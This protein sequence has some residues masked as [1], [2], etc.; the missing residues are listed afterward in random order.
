[1]NDLVSSLRF[2]APTFERDPQPERRPFSDLAI[3]V[4]GQR[5]V[6]GAD[7]G[8]NKGALD[9][10]YPHGLL[11]FLLPYLEQEED[12]FVEL[13]CGNDEFPVAFTHVT[14]SQ[15][16]NGERIP[17]F[18]PHARLPDGVIQPVFFRLTRVNG[19][20]QEE[21]RRQS[22]M[23]DTIAPAGPYDPVPSTPWH[24]GMA[25]PLPPP[26]IIDYGVD[27][28]SAERGVPV[29]IE[30][31]PLDESAPHSWRMAEHDRIRLFIGGVLVEPVHRVTWDE[32]NNRL[33][34]TMTLYYETWLKV[35]DGQKVLEYEAI[36]QC[37]NYSVKWSP[38]TVLKVNIGNDTRPR[39]AY[40]YID[41]SHLG[42]EF[43]TLD[44]DELGE[45][46]DATIVVTQVRQGYERGDA[47]RITFEG[48]TADNAAVREVINYPIPDEEIGRNTRLPLRNAIVR[49][50]VG[51]TAVLSY[52]RIRSGEEPQPSEV[53][54]LAIVG[55]LISRLERPLVLE[56]IGDFLDP[57]LVEATVQIT[58]YTGQNLTDRVD[59]YL[60]GTKANDELEFW[61]FFKMAGSEKDP[62]MFYLRHGPD[63][64]IA[65]LNGG[66]L[67]LH[68]QVGNA[69]GV[70]ESRHT[71]LQV[72][73]ASA[74]LPV[75]N[76][77]EAIG[78]ILDPE[79]ATRG[80]TVVVPK[81]ANLEL[82]DRLNVYWRG[83]KPG[84]SFTYRQF[85]VT[86]QWLNTDIPFP[87]DRQYVDANR[88]GSV[89]ASYLVERGRNTVLYSHVRSLRVGETLDLSR[90]EV[91]EASAP[92]DL[93]NP[94]NAQNVA[95]IRVRYLD[96]KNSDNIQVYW[97]GT[98]GDSG[99]PVIAPKPGNST[100]GY[101]DFAVTGRTVAANIGRFVT[102]RYEVTRDELPLPSKPL[103]LRVL[104]FDEIPGGN[105][106]PPLQIEEATGN[107][108]DVRGSVTFRV[109]AW[110]FYRQG[111]KVWL[112]LESEN[113]SGTTL[114]L[115]IWTASAINGTEFN[116]KYLR[117]VITSTPAHATWLRQLVDGHQLRVVFKV[118]FGGGSNEGD[119]IVFPVRAFTVVN[120]LDS[121]SITSIKTASGRDIDNGDTVVTST[122]T[123]TG[124]AAANQ[125]VEILDEG[126]DTPLAT[127]TADGNG[128]WHTLALTVTAKPY[129][130]TAR[131]LYG[132]NPESLARSFTV[133]ALVTPTLTSVKDPQGNTIGEGDTTTETVFTLTGTASKHQQVSIEDGSGA[134][135]EDL[136]NATADA[137]GEWTFTTRDRP[138][139]A[140]RFYAKSLYHSGNVYSNVR[141]FTIK[142]L[143]APTIRTVKDAS[144][145]EIYNNDNVATTTITLTGSAVANQRVEIR[146][147]G[148]SNPMA[149]VTA[150]GNGDWSTTALA[151]TTKRY[152]IR[153]R[154]IYGSNPESAARTFT[155][156]P[157]LNFDEGAV[158]K[159]ERVYV[160]PGNPDRYPLVNAANSFQRQASGGRTPYTYTSSDTRIATVD[161]RGSVV[162]RGRGTATIQVTDANGQSKSYNITWTQV[163]LCQGL[164]GRNYKNAVS[165]A[166]N[167]GYRLPSLAELNGMNREWGSHWPMGSN[168]YW[169]TDVASATIRKTLNVATGS[170]SSRSEILESLVVAIQS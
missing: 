67:Q 24:E 26:F 11:C 158:S 107:A 54:R 80:A 120:V 20:N 56:A 75:P 6:I 61:H 114:R 36:D 71:L 144:G 76:V 142:V 139:G 161:S 15:A 63:L 1:M 65:G 146:D 25:P 151:V 72:G 10:Y 167:I 30:P 140:R 47:L 21:T 163:T 110:P 164:G 60:L 27:R 81:T 2:P 103:N 170:Q 14:A 40:A 169:S 100:Q 89:R 102:L 35:G 128:E 45:D 84:G 119:A 111:D 90:P 133:T 149:T 159:S 105:P 141:N 122:I 145:K 28:D 88:G 124:T 137:T 91:L 126:N 7:L 168:Y 43:D 152:V 68:Y 150:N 97:E 44:Y 153:A 49:E 52:E 82:D 147:E 121:T 4:Y 79:A 118:V 42:D 156:I 53:T 106:L 134:T 16:L 148:S 37:G 83:S 77:P 113:S 23:V 17:L 70:R 155:V 57:T 108:V 166:Q 74:T 104:S 162:V 9:T 58:P 8:I 123:L 38:Q 62:V 85:D 48:R 165:A 78:G 34:L 93:L 96:M 132:S 115:A 160:I 73:E 129:T 95:T 69:E 50:L 22:L 138:L 136:G 32:A 31:Y 94:I 3:E 125:R 101:V 41:E 98:P 157:V 116:Q 109:N 46:N 99:S 87:I 51:G 13:F 39:L 12:D 117:K 127:V 19:G 59:L 55:S 131:G 130:I 86:S 66:T 64:D 92:G 5:P 143:A 29:T 33:P 112:S 18:I 154:G 135:A